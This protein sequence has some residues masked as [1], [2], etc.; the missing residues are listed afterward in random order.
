MILD[1]IILLFWIECFLLQKLINGVALI[2]TGPVELA[3]V[4]VSIA[5]FNQVSRIAIFPLVSVTTSFVAEEDAIGSVSHE[6]QDCEHL[7]TGSTMNGE[8]KELIPK[9]GILS[10][11]FSLIS[12]FKHF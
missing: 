4:G 1:V 10:F 5:L 6:A 2:H 9:N 7:E 3:A 11:F 12:L 8:D